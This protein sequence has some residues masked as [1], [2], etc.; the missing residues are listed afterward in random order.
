MGEHRWRPLVLFA[1]L[2]LGGATAALAAAGVFQTG[3]PV[4][5]NV[6]PTPKADSGVATTGGV[7]LLALRVTDPA[8]GPPW[9]LRMVH[10][11][12][13]L[14]CLQVGRI[15]DGT[16][17]ALGQDGIFN[18]DGRLHPYAA[19]FLQFGGLECSTLDAHGHG[20]FSATA[21]AL[22]AA[23]LNSGCAPY[24]K[25]SIGS[26]TACPT[27]DLRNVYW[28]LLGP[29]AISITYRTPDGRPAVEK[30][31]GPDG[32]YLIV[33]P[34]TRDICRLFGPP[35]YR[36]R[37][38]GNG[39]TATTQLKSGVILSVH[40]RDAKTC[41]LPPPTPSGDLDVSCPLIGYAPPPSHITPAEVATAIHVHVGR[42]PDLGLGATVSFIARVAT[43][44]SDSFY[45]VHWGEPACGTAS[46]TAATNTDTHAG[47]TVHIPITVGSCPGVEHVTVDYHPPALTGGIVGQQ[48][49][50]NPHAILVGRASFNVP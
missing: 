12:R 11:T 3:A 2:L 47:Q 42:T 10:T 24:A 31:A 38:C 43:Q 15:A 7:Q 22:P 33:G 9:G 23:G 48:I 32:A 45:S 1:V 18:D 37:A 41:R 27:A 25:H 30:T 36:Y 20:F 19:N 14:L 13:G 46:T 16:I 35:R 21:Q 6:P 39:Q 34:P 28:G 8:G 40:Y 4:K 5:P 29:D 26:Y 17:G 44:S 50:S 49:D